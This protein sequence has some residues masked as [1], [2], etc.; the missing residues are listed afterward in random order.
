MVRRL[1]RIRNTVLEQEAKNL[2]MAKR[3]RGNVRPGQRRPIDRRPGSAA[4]PAPAGSAAAS[5]APRPGGLTEAETRR[6]AELEA[7]LLSEERS[8]EAARR[9]TRERAALR[10]ESGPAGSIGLRAETEYA[11]VARD[12]KHIARIAALLFT[13]L[14]GLW[15]VIDVAEIV[16]IG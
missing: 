13:I 1:A 11:Y 12:V 5:V 3:A 2:A 4:A 6:A 8:A 15:I 14:F 7:Q 16:P 9:Q 10:G